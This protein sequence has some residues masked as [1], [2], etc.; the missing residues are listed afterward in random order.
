VILESRTLIDEAARVRAREESMRLKDDFLAAAA[1]DLRTPLTT[2]MG[3][4]QLLERRALREPQAPADLA[5]V[6]IILKEAQRLRGLVLDLLDAARADSGQLVGKRELSDLGAILRGACQDQISSR[7]ECSIEAPAPVMGW[8]DRDRMA[9][10][11]DNLLQNAV[12]YTPA[13][14]PIRIRAWNDPPYSY[15]TIA[16]E[17]VGIPLA[18]MPHVFD[19]FYRADNASDMQFSGLGLGLYICR[20]IVEQ[21]GGAIW[22]APNQPQGTIINIRLPYVEAAAERAAG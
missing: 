6:R 5:A 3:R 10:L 20:T 21:H 17:G 14:G 2:L 15:L 12:K 13:G 4:A 22:A 7:H 9:Q 1:H 11:L 8:F 18:D 19:R 16:D